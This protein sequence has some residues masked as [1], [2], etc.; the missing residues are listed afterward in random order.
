MAG[1]QDALVSSDADIAASFPGH[2]AVDK[3]L[4]LVAANLTARLV[5]VC[6]L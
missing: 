2:L 4:A 6:G 5:L 3:P 1:D